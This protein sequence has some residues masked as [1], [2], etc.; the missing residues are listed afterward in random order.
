MYGHT[1]RSWKRVVHIIS[2][3]HIL[4]PLTPSTFSQE[5]GGLVTFEQFSLDFV[6]VIQIACG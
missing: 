6:S 5:K 1:T 3:K 2:H 4:L